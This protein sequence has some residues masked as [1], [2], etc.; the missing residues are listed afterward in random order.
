MPSTTELRKAYKKLLMGA[1]C[2]QL[3]YLL[4]NDYGILYQFEAH[5]DPAYNSLSNADKF[6]I[7]KECGMVR[8][9]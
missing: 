9:F 3:S 2:L 7:A 4:Y 5:P 6:E 1:N 8:R